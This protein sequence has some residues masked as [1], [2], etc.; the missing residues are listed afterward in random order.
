MLRLTRCKNTINYL[1]NRRISVGPRFLLQNAQEAVNAGDNGLG[2]NLIS[3]SKDAINDVEKVEQQNDNMDK[4]DPVSISIKQMMDAGLHL[5]H[6]TEIWHPNMLPFIYGR[7]NGIHIINLEHTLTYLRRA[8]NFTREVARQG[9]VILFVGMRPFQRNILIQSA[10]YC[11]QFYVHNTWM[12][13]SLVNHKHALKRAS[14]DGVMLQPDLVIVLDPNESRECLDECL[15]V[16][17]PTIGLC[18]TDCDPQQ[19]S[20]PI[21]GND[22]STAS[23]ELIAYLLSCA[24][25]EGRDERLISMGETGDNSD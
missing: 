3:T 14:A 5:G 6:S 23:V 12:P 13:G 8:L 19:V 16:K 11:N 7:R 25:K 2:A 1:A 20:Y 21:P 22:D 18:D 15:K 24:A 10:N 9:G 17:V 4:P